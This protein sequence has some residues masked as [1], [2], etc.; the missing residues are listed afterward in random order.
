MV[1]YV[2]GMGLEDCENCESYFAKSNALA[3]TT[4]YSTV[5]HRQQVISTYMHHTNLCDVYQGLSKS[6]FC[7]FFNFLTIFAA[8]VIGNKYRCALKIK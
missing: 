3:A 6:A 4:R 5:F 2:D 8:I 1:M 7:F